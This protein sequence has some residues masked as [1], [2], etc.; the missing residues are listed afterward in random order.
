MSGN[1]CLKRGSYCAGFHAFIKKRTILALN[2]WT[3]YYFYAKIT[4]VEFS[5]SIM[6]KLTNCMKSLLKESASV[7]SSMPLSSFGTTVLSMALN[8]QSR[9][10]RK[11]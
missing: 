4:I 1:V 11:K 9:A 5:L 3:I 6:N 2:S 8:C 10:E 7:A